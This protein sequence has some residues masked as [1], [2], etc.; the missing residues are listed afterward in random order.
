M[1]TIYPRLGSQ[2]RSRYSDRLWALRPRGRSSIPVRVKNF[3]F[4]VVQTGSGTHTMG[5]GGCFL[6]VK[7]QGSE[8]HHSPPSNAKV[9]KPG[10]IYSLHIRFHGIVL[11][12]SST[13]I[14]LP[15]LT[16][17]PSKISLSAILTFSTRLTPRSPGWFVS[18]VLHACNMPIPSSLILWF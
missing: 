14:A 6:W 1:H 12:E 9:K 3:H 13:G 15:Y 2:H 17:H 8:V 11:S 4:Q 7:W 5:T 16:R 10:F 18:H